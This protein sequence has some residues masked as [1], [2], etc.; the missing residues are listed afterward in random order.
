MTISGASAPLQNPAYEG[1]STFLSSSRSTSGSPAAAILGGYHS[2]P[3]GSMEL[4]SVECVSDTTALSIEE[5]HFSSKIFAWWYLT[6]HD[7]ER[8][9]DGVASHG[10]QLSATSSRLRR[11]S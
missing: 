9:G 8:Q 6:Q 3:V 5:A 10:V 7:R 1:L 4:H 11:L 2:L